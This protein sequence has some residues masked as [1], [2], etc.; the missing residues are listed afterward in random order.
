MASNKKNQP[1]EPSNTR[2]FTLV[3]LLVVIA[4]I[5]ILI[6]LLLPAIQAAREA[7]RRLQ[8]RNN[9]KQ[10]GVACLTH[11][12]RQGHYPS[13]G[14]GNRWVG[15]PDGGYGKKQPGGWVYNILPGLEL[16]G[17]HDMGKGKSIT[18]KM[19][20]GNT[21]IRSPLAV[22]NCPT[23]RPS[24]LYPIVPS[25]TASL[26][27]ANAS[28]VVAR[29]DYAACAAT[30]TLININNMGGP[31]SFSAAASFSWT[32]TDN[33]TDPG[34]YLNGVIYVRSITTQKDIRRGTSHTIMVGEKYLNPD[35]YLTG[36][37]G[38]DNENLYQGYDVD[39]FRV[40]YADADNTQPLRDRKGVATDHYFGSAHVAAC[41]FV[42]CDGAVHGISYDVNPDAFRTY[43]ARKITTGLA[44]ITPLSSEPVFS[45]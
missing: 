23:R 5:G 22:M 16:V 33:S 39:N 26:V 20:S 29:G 35:A 7:A 37:D 36:M 27:N 9:L 38:G 12:E 30:K 40:T 41:N 18:D 42:L 1:K 6:A 32:N 44:D 14:W 15:D 25:R 43:G 24:I 11:V 17:L 31:A 34:N 2:A 8:C 19:Q 10:I 13:G 3:E 21:L 45:D 28:D 4:I